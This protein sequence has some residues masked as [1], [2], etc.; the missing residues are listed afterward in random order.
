MLPQHAHEQRRVDRY[1]DRPSSEVA[2]GKER[3]PAA[4][5]DQE[6]HD[7]EAHPRRVEKAAGEDDPRSREDCECAVEE[8]LDCLHRREQD[9]NREQGDGLRLASHGIGDHPSETDD[10]EDDHRPEAQDR[11]ERE[12]ERAGRP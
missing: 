3:D 12:D 8:V 7:G 2:V 1:A 10:E 11:G 4:R 6:R 5:Q 9:Q